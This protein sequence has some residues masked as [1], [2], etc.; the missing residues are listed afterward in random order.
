[1]YYY[2]KGGAFLDEWR[3]GTRTTRAVPYYVVCMAWRGLKMLCHRGEEGEKKEEKK[4]KFKKTISKRR[5]MP[6]KEQGGFGNDPP[7]PLTFCPNTIR[8]LRR[9]HPPAA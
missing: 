7:G 9:N 4:R 3:R 6:Q 1:M 8:I 5:H 2:Y